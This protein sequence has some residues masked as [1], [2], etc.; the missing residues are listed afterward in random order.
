MTVVA[1]MFLRTLAVGW[2]GWLLDAVMLGLGASMLSV[3][4]LAPLARSLRWS[5]AY[6]TL[7][8]AVFA[9][10]VAVTTVA[11]VAYLR[12]LARSFRHQPPGYHL[13]VA[14]WAA[15]TAVY[16]EAV[17]RLAAQSMLCAVLPATGAVVLV[18]AMFTFWH[19]HR[20]GSNV[21]LVA[22]LFSF[23]LIQ[24]WAFFATADLLLI[25]LTHAVRNYLIGINGYAIE[26]S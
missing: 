25:T 9:A 7:A 8:L 15:A 13:R 16:E 17:W 22:E 2:C 12:G 21:L 5:P 4:A 23:S 10:S 20:T 18:A 19:R 14:A 24:G 26:K 11:P 1:L 6:L 3:G